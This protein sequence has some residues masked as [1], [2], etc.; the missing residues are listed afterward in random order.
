MIFFNDGDDTLDDNDDYD[1]GTDDDDN[2]DDCHYWASL[3][4]QLSL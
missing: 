1:D 2:D 4:G 3:V